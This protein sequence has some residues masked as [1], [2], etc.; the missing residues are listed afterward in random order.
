MNNRRLYNIPF[1]EKDYYANLKD[2]NKEKEYEIGI[3]IPRI[4]RACNTYQKINNKVLI[5]ELGAIN[6]YK[7]YDIDYTFN[8]VNIYAIAFFN[9]L[10]A[11]NITLAYELTFRQIAELI[12]TNNKLVEENKNNELIILGLQAQIK[13]LE[14][15]EL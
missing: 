2:Y 15:K 1:I 6:N 14:N 3:N 8:V 4:D 9:E 13:K 11:D 7:N 12:N 10:G 5:T